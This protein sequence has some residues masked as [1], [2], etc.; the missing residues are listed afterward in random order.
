MDPTIDQEIDRILGLVSRARNVFGADNPPV[1]PPEF[2]P[3][4]DLEDNLG[5]GHF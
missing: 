3:S 5:R 2:T 1:V 4:R